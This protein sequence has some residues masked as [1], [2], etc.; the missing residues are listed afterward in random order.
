MRGGVESTWKDWVRAVYF[1]K[2]R[3]TDLEQAMGSSQDPGTDCTTIL[4][5]LTPEERSFAFVPVMRGSII[6]VGRF[7]G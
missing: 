4:D 2:R 7:L 3:R 1:R 5:S 6:A